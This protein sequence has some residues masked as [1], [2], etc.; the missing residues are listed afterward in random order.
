MAPVGK[1]ANDADAF[2]K[3][4]NR[5]KSKNEDDRGLK[6]GTDIVY[7]DVYGGVADDESEFVT[8]LPTEDE[9]RKIFGYES[10]R[11]REQMED[12]DEGRVSSHPSSLAA[13]VA[14]GKVSIVFWIL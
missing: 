3:L 4:P 14:T 13:S 8:S 6:F 2:E 11:V 10:V 5:S 1:N 9:E 12:L 7:G